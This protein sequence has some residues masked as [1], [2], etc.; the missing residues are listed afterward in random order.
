MADADYDVVM[1]G[2]GV[3]AMTAAL[4][5]AKYGGMKIC[6][7]ERRHEVA[8]GLSTEQAAPGFPNNTHCAFISPWHFDPILRDFPEMEDYG[9]KFVPA[10]IT[11]A[12]TF[13]DETCL[14]MYGDTADPTGERTAKELARFSERDAETWLKHH[15]LSQ[16]MWLPALNESISNPPG[17]PGMPSAIDLLLFHPDSGLDPQLAFMSPYQVLNTLFESPEFISHILRV[18]GA[19]GIYGDDAG[20]GLF[21]LIGGHQQDLGTVEGGTHNLAHAYHRALLKYGV[22]ITPHADVTKVVVENGVAKGV[23]LADGTRIDA[24]QFVVTNVS[25]RQLCF[26]LLGNEHFQGDLLRRV[27]NLEDFRV[28]ITWFQWAMSESPVYSS[29]GFNPDINGSVGTVIMGGNKDPMR[30]MRECAQ[31]RMRT[32]PPDPVMLAYNHTSH[33]PVSSPREGFGATMLTETE[34][35]PAYAMTEKEWI[36]W[37]KRHA[38]YVIEEIHRYAPNISWDTVLGN[39]PVSPYTI[40]RDGENWAPAGNWKSIDTNIAQSGGNRPIPQLAR[41]TVPWIKSL[42]CTGA[43]WWPGFGAT[44]HE[45][46]NCY[47]IIAEDHGLRKPWDEEGYPY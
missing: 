2:A 18:L 24:R 1:V 13:E 35:L 38:D 17:M 21:A 32:D 4:Y 41:Y 36:A 26:D 5:L 9:A 28:C 37:H 30:W 12:S 44:P 45:G 25:P 3:K 20:M 10:D 29:G 43:G 6:I 16:E 15:Q 47:K 46:Y 22:T 40:A 39:L 23:L 19:W 42:Y 27:E 33:D 31:L 34:A 8:A 14:C 7:L 11:W